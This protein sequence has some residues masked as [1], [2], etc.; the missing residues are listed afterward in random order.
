M[1]FEGGVIVVLV[2]C[3]INVVVI[4][5]VDVNNIDFWNMVIQD[6]IGGI[7]VCFVDFYS[8]VLGEEV[9]ISVGGDELSEFNGLFQ[10]NDVDNVDV[11][12]MGNGILLELCDVIIQEILDNVEVWEF[13]LVKVFDVF[14]IEGGI[15]FGVKMLDDGIVIIV[16]FI[17]S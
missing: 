11:I 14:Y 12:S 3:F 13:I 10:I 4:L 7:V 2:N 8:F 5:D 15:F 1:L 16:I 17:C 9:E 6:E